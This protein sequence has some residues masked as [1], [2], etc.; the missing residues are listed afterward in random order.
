MVRPPGWSQGMLID[1]FRGD[2]LSISCPLTSFCAMVD[3]YAYAFIYSGSSWSSPDEIDPGNYL[4][5]VSCPTTSF[6]VAVDAEGNVFTYNGTVV[7][8]DILDRVGIV[9]CPSPVRRRA[10]APPWTRLATSSPTT[11]ARGRRPTVIRPGGP[12]LLT[13]SPARRRASAPQWTGRQRP[14]LQRQL[15]VVTR[16][17]RPSQTG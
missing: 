10:S 5:S 3:S 17:H 12:D 14:H 1:P 16:P 7:V 4:E 11:A 8:T 6:C 2:P 15:V 13:P 9:S